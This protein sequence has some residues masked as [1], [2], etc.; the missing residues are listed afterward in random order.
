VLASEELNFTRNVEMNEGILEA[1]FAA[2]MEVALYHHRTLHVLAIEMRFIFH[3]VIFSVKV[4]VN[5]REVPW[6]WP[7]TE[8]L[9]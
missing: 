6:F 5:D 1:G 8:V 7:E 9:G 2:H 4:V 3:K